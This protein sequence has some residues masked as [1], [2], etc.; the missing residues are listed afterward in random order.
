MSG[1]LGLVVTLALVLPATSGATFPGMNGRIAFYTNRFAANYEVATVKPDGTDTKRLTHTAGDDTEATFSPNGNLILYVHDGADGVHVW[2][3]SADGTNK[4]ELDL[5][6]ADTFQPTWAPGGTR[7]AYGRG[8]QIWTANLNGTNR[9]QITSGPELHQSADWSPSGNWIAY[10]LVDA[11]GTD[12]D[13]V[14]INPKGGGFVDITP[15]GRAHDLSPRWSPNGGRLIFTRF[16]DPMYDNGDIFTVKADG[17]DVQKMIATSADEITPTYA[18]SGKR[19][20]YSSDTTGNL[21]LWTKSVL[22]IGLPAQTTN[23]P[24]LDNIAPDWQAR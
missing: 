14:K 22:A 2:R 8:T 10:D 11:N 9:Q 21:E 15:S 20:A 17:T 4:Q 12:H 24:G 19:V 13:I 6:A 16:L 3:M 1:V 7:L 23:S 5:G 18:P